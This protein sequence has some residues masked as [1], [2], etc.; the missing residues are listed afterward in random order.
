MSWVALCAA[1][2]AAVLA[3]L[4][5]G[6]ALGVWLAK[7]VAAGAFVAAALA[8]G[9]LEW[10]VGRWIAAA[11]ALSW[12]GD[13]LLLPRRTRAR[14]PAR[15]GELRRRPSRV[16][17]GLRRR[18]RLRPTHA[19][20]GRARRPGA[21]RGHALAAPAPARPAAPRGASL[22]PRDRGDGRPRGGGRGEPRPARARG[23]RRALRALRPLRRA[24]ALP[25]PGPR[26]L[27]LGPAGLLRRPAPPGGCL[28]PGPRAALNCA[29]AALEVSVVT[30]STRGATYLTVPEPPLR[31]AIVPAASPPRNLRADLGGCPGAPI[32]KP[33]PCAP[34]RARPRGLRAP[35]RGGGA[36]RGCADASGRRCRERAGG[37]RS[38]GARR[39]RR[40]P[41]PAQPGGVP[42]SLRAHA[43]RLLAAERRERL[44]PPRD[45]LVSGASGLR[46]A[47]LRTRP[48]LPLPHRRDARGAGPAARARA[49]PGDRERLR[50]LRPLPRPRFGA[51][52]VHREHR[53]TLRPRPGLVGRRPPRRAR[54]D[55]RR[56]R[57]PG[58]APRGVRRRLAARARRLQLRRAERQ[59]GD[60]A[61]PAQRPPDR[62]LRPRPPGRD[63]RL[64]A[65]AA[66]D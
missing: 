18:R 16:L 56:P 42:R 34:V 13:V 9:A 50:S 64:R 65:E 8:S 33:L 14:L 31:A 30:V 24:R 7:P 27:G 44:G 63:A 61:Q 22:R 37:S 17:G 58:G 12:L 35:A 20:V 3:S 53:T 49:G 41:D 51:L 39:A 5:R 54:G 1:A 38:G 60:R 26:E 15:H 28:W 25:R 66:R 32:R 6:S 47:E 45:R 59:E 40:R 11:L 4:W 36:S 46:R 2:C 23:R 57:A 52:A 48:A 10:E 43:L 29:L 21:P 62:L 55:A 19:G